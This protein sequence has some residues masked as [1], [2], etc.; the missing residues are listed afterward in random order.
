MFK[1]N[2]YKVNFFQYNDRFPKKLHKFLSLDIIFTNRYL[3]SDHLNPY[4]FVFWG[5]KAGIIFFHKK[6]DELIFFSITSRL[7]KQLEKFFCLHLFFAN[8]VFWHRFLPSDHLNPCWFCFFWGI[9]ARNFFFSTTIKLK[10]N[11]FSILI[12]LPKSSINFSP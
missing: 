8:R 2:Q 4:F 3:P 11:F 10:L 6:Q 1:K 12:R 5:I 9:K 7:P